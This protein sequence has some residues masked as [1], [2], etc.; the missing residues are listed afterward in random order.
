MDVRGNQIATLCVTTPNSP[1]ARMQM[2]SQGEW[3]EFLLGSELGR[4]IRL[5]L[6]PEG[7]CSLGRKSWAS[8]FE[9]TDWNPV[10][11][12]SGLDRV[13]GGGLKAFRLWAALMGLA[14][15]RGKKT[16]RSSN[17]FVTGTDTSDAAVIWAMSF[18]MKNPKTMKKVQDEIRSLIGKKGFVDEDDI[19]QLPCLKAVVK[20][21]MRLQ[22]TVALLVPRET[23]H[24]CTLGEYEIAEKTLV[25]V[26][27]WPIGRDPEA[28]EKPLEFCP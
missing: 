24:K 6:G 25:Y 28:W 27:A 20:E 16:Q 19:Q 17:V 12:L 14:L 22:P 4:K 7:I 21:M 15:D 8:L 23:V 18:L 5:R 9:E 3:V 11:E 10:F 2:V 26:N 13:L 1:R